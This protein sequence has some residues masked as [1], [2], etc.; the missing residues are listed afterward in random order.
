M[1]PFDHRDFDGHQLL[2]FRE[3]RA[4]GLRAIIAVHNT[5]LGPALGGCRMFPYSSHER[6]L[7]DVLRLSRGMTY[8]NAL[9]GLPYGG[10]KAV[11]IGDPRRHKSRELLLAMAEFVEGLAG[12]YITAEDSGTGAADM[13]VLAERTAYVSGVDNGDA[14]G[15]PS[16][17]TAYGV[18][19]GIRAAV[20]HKFRSD[21]S[22]VRVAVQGVGNVGYHLVEYLIG[23]GAQVSV[24]DI[25][26]DNVRRVVALGARAV[27]VGE[28]LFADVD[29]VAPCA[30][31]GAINPDSVDRIRAGVVAGSA[32]NQLATADMGQRL[33]QRNILYAPD[34]VINAGGVID[35]YYQ[36]RRVRDRGQVLAHVERIGDTLVQ[37]FRSSGSSREATS[38]IA[39]RMAE[40]IFMGTGGGSHSSHPVE[41]VG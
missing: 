19:C 9:A 18:F 7:S 36:L 14:G 4:S 1:T 20:A 31:G 16:P 30:M 27:D 15:D 41:A 38:V 3:D 5:H 32:N 21:L 23:A 10:G 24:A 40:A 35:V 13:A 29:V 11:I 26:L 17:V 22:G 25:N 12:Q 8:K 33:L 37:I 6:A 34:Y 39:D 2:A 28:V